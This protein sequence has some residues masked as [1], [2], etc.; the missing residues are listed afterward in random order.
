MRFLAA[1][2]LLLMLATKP[3]RAAILDTL[4][5][6]DRA[7]E[8]AHQ[9]TSEHSA[10]IAAAALGES[11]RQLLPLDPPQIEGG[12]IAFTMAVDPDR[13]NYF[14]IKLWGSDVSHDR[15]ILFCDGKQ[16]GY[17]HLGDV[18]LLDVGND[19]GEPPYNGRFY[20]ATSPMPLEMTRGKTTLQCEIRCIGKIWPYG[21]KFSE[22]QSAM[23][24]PTKGIYRVYTHTEGDFVPPADETQGNAAVDPPIRQ[25]PGPEVIEQVK[26]R[27]NQTLTGLLANHKPLNEMEMQ[28]VARAYRISWTM[29]YHNPRAVEQI[30]RGMDALFHEFDANPR[31]AEL[32]P[33]T[34]NPDWFPFGPAGDAVRLLASQLSPVLDQSIDSKTG[35]LPRRAAWSRMLQAGRDWHRRHRRLY[36]NQ[37]M[38]TDMNIFLSNCGVRAIDPAHAVPDAQLL[39]YLYQS[40]GLEPWLGSDTDSGPEKPKGDHYFELTDKGLT[41]ELGY[42]GTYGEVLDWA[43]QIYDATRP[44]PGLP[45]N[46]KIM[47]QLEKIAHTRAVFRYPALDA[48]GNR[49]MRIETMVGWRDDHHPG[50]VVYGERTTWDATPLYMAA[51]TLDP[52]EVGYAQQMF[53]DNEYFWLIQ[54]RMKTPGLR[55]TAGLLNEPDQY[56]LIKEQPASPY[57]LPMSNGGRD[58]AW[59]DEQDGVVAIKHGNDIFYASL[60]WRAKYAI[61][62]LARVH[63]ISPRYERIAVL[64]EQTDFID[65]GQIYTRPDWIDQYMAH[66]GYTYPGGLHSALAGE[67][68][69]IAQFPP[70]DTTRYGSEDPFAGRGTFYQLRYGN[71]LIGMNSSDQKTFQLAVPAGLGQA[72]DLIS[73]TVRNLSEPINIPPRSTVVLWLGH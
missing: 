47:L 52:Q 43:T 16:V 22:Y 14:T 65:S 48:D 7:D 21:T 72:R 56:A 64:S 45:G 70:G 41:K 51:A 11:A 30:V 44:E 35:R 73:G 37:S 55:V 4:V 67:Q 32:D 36:T 31:L 40:V 24:D 15:L 13:Q 57:R 10:I 5:F 1:C 38:I 27:V 33:A 69:P 60:Y 25:S 58:F 8:A 6:G 62:F 54:N 3:S 39:D 61:N 71:Y 12:R 34:P 9:L 53:A 49:A 23:T 26:S 19:I 20:Y 17:H 66:G 63:D 59:A 50:D 42:V 29:A 68:L 18:D 2:S 46:Q 28:F